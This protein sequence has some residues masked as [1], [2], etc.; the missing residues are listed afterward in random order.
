LVRAQHYRWWYCKAERL[1]GL[2]VDHHLELGRKLHREIARLL[3]AQNAIDIG[4]GTTPRVYRVDSV[5]E[6]AA[7]SGKIRI[8]IDRRYPA[9]GRRRYDRRAMHDHERIRLDD[10]AA[11]QL[12]PKGDDGLFDLCVAVN[13]LSDWLDLERRSRRL[14]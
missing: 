2:A 3:A 7:V 1:G 4:G 10:K 6:Q 13:R 9:P 8:H 11:S 5:G 14:K 12:A